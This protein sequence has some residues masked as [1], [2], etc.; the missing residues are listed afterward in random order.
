[1]HACSLKLTFSIANLF[2]ELSVQ[3]L[4]GSLPVRATPLFKTSVKK[5][6]SKLVITFFTK[7]LAIEAILE[8]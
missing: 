3:G 5:Q 8:H 7:R 6:L 4:T 1:M 2:K